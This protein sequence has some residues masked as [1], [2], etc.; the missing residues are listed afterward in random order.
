[1]RSA[2]LHDSWRRAPLLRAI[3]ARGAPVV[4]LD[5]RLWGQVSLVCKRVVDRFAQVV[6][7]FVTGAF[8]ARSDVMALA[9]PA[10]GHE[11]PRDPVTQECAGCA[12]RGGPVHRGRQALSG[13]SCA[14]RRD[15][16]LTRRVSTLWDRFLTSLIMS[17]YSGHPRHSPRCPR[18]AQ[19][20][21]SRA[22][23]A[24]RRAAVDLQ[25][26]AE[27][28]RRRRRTTMGMRRAAVSPGTGDALQPCRP[29]GE[30][31]PPLGAQG[32]RDTRFRAILG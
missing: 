20:G 19:R 15:F 23:R 32:Y 29:F 10:P 3:S 21:R 9:L 27:D 2:R 26:N 31:C 13:S 16:A 24:R 8:V 6:R 18:P 7:G 5:L 14:F 11:P 22:A 17:F 30:H 25:P 4:V 12:D 1:M 28:P